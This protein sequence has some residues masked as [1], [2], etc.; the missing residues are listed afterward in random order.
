M[1]PCAAMRSGSIDRPPRRERVDWFNHMCCG[2]ATCCANAGLRRRSLPSLW[3]WDLCLRPRPLTI[4]HPLGGGHWASHVWTAEW[5]SCSFFPPSSLFSR[6]LVCSSTWLR[7]PSPLW[8]IGLLWYPLASAC[9]SQRTTS[10]FTADA[11]WWSPSQFPRCEVQAV[12]PR[13][14]ELP[15]AQL[16][17]SAEHIDAMTVLATVSAL[18]PRAAPRAEKVLDLWRY[19][20]ASPTALRCPPSPIERWT[21]TSQ[22]SPS[23]MRR[24]PAGF[25]DQASSDH[26]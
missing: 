7:V 17:L 4:V 10:V 11:C 5:I 9:P 25:L 13:Y 15:Q 3:S 20:E 23:S 21:S 8:I 14:R 2:W 22:I 12:S 16:Q 26:D 1:T 19:L 24:L 6:T 18:L